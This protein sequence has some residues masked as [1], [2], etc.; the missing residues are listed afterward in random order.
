MGIS[1]DS[2]NVLPQDA[3]DA[4]LVARVFDP[5]AGGPSVVAIRGEEVVDLS[6]LT[7]T[8]SSLLVM[9]SPPSA[10]DRRWRMALPPVDLQRD[11]NAG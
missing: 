8:V 10:L 3:A 4:T 9:R 5:S 1:L 2:A 6:P 11:C 7:P